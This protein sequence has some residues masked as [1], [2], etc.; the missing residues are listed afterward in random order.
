LRELAGAV[1]VEIRP[2]SVWWSVPPVAVSDLPWRLS[3]ARKSWSV[4]FA[5]AVTAE[6]SGSTSMAFG[7]PDVSSSASETTICEHE[8][9]D[10]G[11]RTRPPPSAPLWIR[12]STA[13]SSS[14]LVGRTR[15]S[16]WK[17][18]TWP[19]SCRTGPAVGRVTGSAAPLWAMLSLRML[20]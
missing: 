6:P 18:M 5:V 14:M 4:T 17:E 16:G 19:Q 9:S 20:L 15:N 11:T 7:R 13:S 1:A 2:A 12:S 8:C 10:P 3:S